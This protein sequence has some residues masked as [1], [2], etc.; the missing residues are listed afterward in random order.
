MCRKILSYILIGITFPS[1][2]GSNLSRHLSFYCILFLVFVLNTSLTLRKLKTFI[3]L[4]LI[5]VFPTLYLL[6]FGMCHEQVLIFYHLRDFL[7]PG[8]CIPSQNGLPPHTIS[9]SCHTLG[10]FLACVNFHSIYSL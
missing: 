9:I 3:L 8:F 6:C 5:P 10:I 1:L 4:H 7:Y 2:P